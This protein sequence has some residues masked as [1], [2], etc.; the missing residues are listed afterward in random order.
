MR[1]AIFLAPEALKDLQD[2][3]A[4]ARAEVQDAIDATRH[5][6]SRLSKSRIK[7]LRGLSRLQYRLR[8]SDDV[9]VFYD[10]TEDKVEVL[11]IVTKAEA[12]KWLER[13]GEANEEGGTI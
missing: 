12:D 3:K 4:N 7:R 6:P 1:Y 2:L 11:A 5:D 10:V 8:V 13:Y 9:R